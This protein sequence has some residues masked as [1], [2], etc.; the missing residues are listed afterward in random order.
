MISEEYLYAIA[1]RECNQI[2]DI[3]FHK[4]V[5]TFG[6]AQEAWKKAKK[7]IKHSK[8]WDKKL[9]LTSADRII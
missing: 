3:N 5:R 9:F 1:L 6:S 2:G 8:G 4:L 7:N